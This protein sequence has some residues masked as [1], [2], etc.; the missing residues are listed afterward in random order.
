[1]Y[2]ARDSRVVTMLRKGHNGVAL[3]PGELGRIAMWI[4]CNAIFYGAHLPGEQNKQLR[5]EPIPMPM[6]Q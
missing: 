4:D 5:G 2:G 3:S 6:W 1:M